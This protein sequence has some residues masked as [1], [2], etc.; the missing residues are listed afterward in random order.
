MDPIDSLIYRCARQ[1]ELYLYLRK[2][3]RMDSLPAALRQRTG[4]LTEVMP[5]ALTPTRHLARVD[6]AQVYAALRDHGHYLQLPPD[7][8]V[9]A[10][11]Y[12]GD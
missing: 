1:P 8:R 10:H 4:R 11:L 9:Q 2:D 5:L 3:I 6:A 7:G 12:T